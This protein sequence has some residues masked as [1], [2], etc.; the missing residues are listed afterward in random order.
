VRKRLKNFFPYAGYLA[1]PFQYMC[2]VDELYP[3]LFLFIHITSKDFHIAL[4]Q[5][6]LE[7]ICHVVSTRRS[8]RESHD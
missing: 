6:I 5:L 3:N 7:W 1:Y 2:D 8:E 4:S